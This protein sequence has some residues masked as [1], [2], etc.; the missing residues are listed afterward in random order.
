M[1]EN[2]EYSERDFEDWK[3]DYNEWGDLDREYYTY[4]EEYIEDEGAAD[5]MQ[6]FKQFAYAKYEKFLHEVHKD[7]DLDDE[8]DPYPYGEDEE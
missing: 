1:D 2:R 4:V 5:D 7:D 6:T 3:A 8:D